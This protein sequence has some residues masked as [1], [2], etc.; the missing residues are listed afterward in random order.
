MKK[1]ILN[2]MKKN[3][4]IFYATLL[5]LTIVSCSKNYLDVNVDP[6]NPATAT[7]ELALPAGTVASGAVIGGY[8]NLLGGM[9]SQYWT[10]SAASNQYKYIDSYQLLSSD[11]EDQWAD[12]Y[13]NSLKNLKY[14]REQATIQKK[15]AYVFISTVIESYTYQ[16]LVDLYDQIPFNDALQGEVLHNTHAHFDN[17]ATVYDSIAV[18]LERLFDLDLDAIPLTVEQQKQDFVFFKA[19]APILYTVEM[20]NWKAFANTLLLKIYLRQMYV[21]PDVAKAGISALYARNAVFLTSDAKLDIFIDAANRDNPLYESDRRGL[22]TATNLRASATLFRY[23]FYQNDPRRLKIYGNGP[24]STQRPYPLPQGGVSVP[25]NAD[26]TKGFPIARTSIV[27]LNATDPVYFIS[28]AESYFLQ[29]EAVA[30]GWGIG[31]DQALYDAGVQASFTK[32]GLDG[33]KM[34]AGDYAYPTSGNFE[35]KQE[36]I[37]MQKW[38]SMATSEGIEAF[39]ETNRT[40]YPKT[41]A[42]TYII[43]GDNTK[44]FD[45]T[46][47]ELTYS[48][49]GVTNG[50]FPKRLLFPNSEITANPNTPALVPITQKVW[51][52]TK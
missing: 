10:Q 32:Y 11:F 27:N 4:I 51:W 44:Y 22:N 49:I 46:G 6:N 2:T 36:A 16:V 7:P 50:K 20:A 45:W 40:H 15:W 48:L 8:Y 31:D 18:R 34:L 29:A 24:G 25:D 47:G 38:I 28:T 41:T 52:D 14:V 13:T 17:A 42:L 37:I 19:N 9:W 1:I 43:G 35:Q 30:K 21:R 5:F 26:T 23:L 33:T 12:L 3:N 39:F